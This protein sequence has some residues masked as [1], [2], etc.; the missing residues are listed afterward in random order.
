MR[1]KSAVARVTRRGERLKVFGV[2][3]TD[4]TPLKSVDVRVDDGTWQQATIDRQDNPH[5]WAFWSLETAVPRAGEHTIVSKATD[6]QGGTQPDNLATKK[7][8]WENNELF[9]RKV[10]VS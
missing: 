7:T 6:R 4:G 5:A 3:W 8:I 1:V 9:V 2:A 10:M